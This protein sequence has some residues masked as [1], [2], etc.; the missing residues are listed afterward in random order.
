MEY[1]CIGMDIDM[2]IGGAQL[3]QYPHQMLGPAIASIFQPVDPLASV[4]KLQLGNRDTPG[5]Q[6]KYPRFL[7]IGNRDTSPISMDMNICAWNVHA[8]AW[9]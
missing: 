6:E 8:W 7:Q 1:A 2:G 9:A 4:P 3:H 5:F